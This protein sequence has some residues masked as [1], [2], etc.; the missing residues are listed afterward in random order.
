MK[1][2]SCSVTDSSTACNAMARVGTLTPGCPHQPCNPMHPHP[3]LLGSRSDPRPEEG[4]S[5]RAFQALR[6]GD[7]NKSRT[8]A[9]VGR[10]SVRRP[11]RQ[12]TL[13]HSS[14]C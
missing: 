3:R 8:Q 14:I 1:R 13:A 7:G 9:L 4:Q 2:L 10:G 11:S 5:T 6:E 12:Q